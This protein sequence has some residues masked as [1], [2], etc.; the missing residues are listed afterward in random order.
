M[1]HFPAESLV[2][3]DRNTQARGEA[4]ELLHDSLLLAL[5]G[6]RRW[7]PTNVSFVPWLLGVIRSVSSNWAKTY[8]P[9]EDPVLDSQMVSK[10]KDE[11]GKE[12][13]ISLQDIGDGAPNPERVLRAKQ[14]LEELRALFDDDAEADLVIDSW[15]E[16]MDGPAIQDALD[17]SQTQ[18]QT[19][20]RRIRRRLG[21]KGIGVGHYVQ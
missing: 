16:G 20:V 7:K 3:F 14:T 13:V 4:Q 11:K 6:E 19:V 8:K 10:D 15:R 21:T 17:W 5:N 9:E 12:K 1:V 18:Y 2:H